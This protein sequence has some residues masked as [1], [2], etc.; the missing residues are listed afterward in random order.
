MCDKE[1]DIGGQ[2]HWAA[3]ATGKH[4][5]HYLLDYFKV[6]LPKYGVELRTGVE[7]TAELVQKEKPDVV[8][9]ATG[10]APFKPP[11]SAVEAP[12]VHQAWDVLKGNV[13]TGADVV[14][15]GG[16]SVGLETPFL[17]PQKEPY[18]PSNCIFSHSTR[19]NRPKSFVNL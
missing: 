2:V 1:D 8:V 3:S 6:A 12:N 10:A 17:L 4:D 13:E 16:G 19:Q 7:V 9:V 5:F 14:V 11:I 15:V 18:H